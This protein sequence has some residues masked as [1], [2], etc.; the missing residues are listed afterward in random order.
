M[1][2]QIKAVRSYQG[3]MVGISR[4]NVRFLLCSHTTISYQVRLL[5]VKF[6]YECTFFIA[7]STSFAAL[8][9]VFSGKCVPHFHS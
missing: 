6:M 5:Q 7:K 8:S 1:M 9:N 3:G 4:T 2:M